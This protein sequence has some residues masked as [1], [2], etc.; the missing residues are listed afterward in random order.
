MSRCKYRHYRYLKNKLKEQPLTGPLELAN[1]SLS[2]LLHCN[3]LAIMT[4]VRTAIIS[5]CTEIHLGRTHKSGALNQFP[6]QEHDNHNGNLNIVR[7]KV[8]TLEVRAEAFPSLNED[9]NDIQSHG[10][11]RSVRIGPVLEWKEVLNALCLNRTAEAERS[12]TDTDP[13]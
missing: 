8:D 12:K 5:I 3:F 11:N 6:D 13:G 2:L 7:D 4:I 10:K 9:Q 1:E